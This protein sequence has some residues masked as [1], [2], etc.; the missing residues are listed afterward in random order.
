MKN[1][2]KAVCLTLTV[3]SVPVSAYACIVPNYN[4]V[5]EHQS[6]AAIPYADVKYYVHK[7]ING[8]KMHRLW[9]ETKGKYETA[10]I[11]CNCK[12]S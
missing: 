7:M 8:K 9:N 5:A 4:T 11:V 10:W 1:Y 3:A 2:I 6:E 12:K